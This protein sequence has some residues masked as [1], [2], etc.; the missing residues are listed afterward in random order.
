M[1]VSTA[2]VAFWRSKPAAFATALT[3][4]FLTT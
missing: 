3:M 1:I 2:C 4:S